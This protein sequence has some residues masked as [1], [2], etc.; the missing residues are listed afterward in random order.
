MYIKEGKKKNT[1]I[2]KKIRTYST[3]LIQKRGKIVK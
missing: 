2:L 3:Q 1:H